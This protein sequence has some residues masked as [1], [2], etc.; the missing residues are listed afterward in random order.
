MRPTLGILIRF[1]N[2]AAT[3]PR[4][5]HRLH[6]Q[7]LR[8]HTILGV[9]TGST[10][11]SAALITQA[12]G[13]VVAWTQ[14]YHHARV[15][16]YGLTHLQT[17]LILVLSS[18]TTLD[19]DDALE[20]MCAA[21]E[22]PRVACV[23]AKWDDDPYYS[24][25]ITWDELLVKG[26]KFGSIY[27][28]SMGMIRRKAWEAVPFDETLL[29]AEDY[30]WAIE[31]LRLGHICKRLPLRFG[32]DRSGHDRTFEF[33]QLVFHFARR[34]KLHVAWLGATRS[35]QQMLKALVMPR[36][37]MPSP[38]FHYQRLKA[39]ALMRFTAASSFSGR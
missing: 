6:A 37:G 36:P 12:G 10:D 15:L 19:D 21:F 27:S 35:L 20:Q 23:S 13:S 29:T 16:N 5:L 32:Y 1:K 33:A 9:D 3:L 34:Y 26:L 24:D 7:T 22:N 14:P 8:P 11:G 31:Q 30:A 4:V 2:S 18:H 39:W 28:N 17:D 25:A 38:A